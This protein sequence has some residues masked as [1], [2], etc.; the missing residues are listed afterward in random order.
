MRHYPKYL[1]KADDEFDSI[2]F[3]QLVQDLNQINEASV[4]VPQT[5]K[6]EILISFTKIHS[7]KHEWIN[8][9]PMFAELVTTGELPIGN[10]ASLFEASSKN[11]YFQQQFERFLQQRINS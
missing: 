6:A 11:S 1:V 9:N 10:I 5:L 4:N 3:P 2:N 7:L 8:A